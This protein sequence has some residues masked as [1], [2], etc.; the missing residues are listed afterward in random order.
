M[1]KYKFIPTLFMP[2]VTAR[3]RS[4]YYRYKVTTNKGKNRSGIYYA[5][6]PKSAESGVKRYYKNSKKV[7]VYKRPAYKYR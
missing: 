1:F 4:K 2:R 6:S 3:S 7:F 5:T